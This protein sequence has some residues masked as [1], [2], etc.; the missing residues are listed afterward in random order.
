MHPPKAVTRVHSDERDDGHEDDE[1]EGWVGRKVDALFSPV[2]HFL[3]DNEK[4]T[5]GEEVSATPVMQQSSEDDDFSDEGSLQGVV[6]MEDDDFNPWQFIKSLPPYDMVKHLTPAVTLPPKAH[7]AP[8]I[9]LV[10]DLDETLVH[11]SVEE[12]SSCDLEFGVEFHGMDYQVYVKLR[13]HLQ[14]FLT[15]VSGQFEVIVFTASQPVYANELLDRIDPHRQLVHHRLFRDSCLQ[16]EGNF[17]KDLSVL[18]RDLKTT[19]LV[20]NSPHAFGYQLDNGVP[21]ES[22]FDDD[23]DRELVKL[24]RF[25]RQLHGQTDVRKTLRTKFQNNTRVKEAPAYGHGL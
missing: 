20:D 19:I 17:L 15:A 1:G 21:I 10:L 9:T 23:S 18:G 22:W 16:V 2:L 12:P 14:R 3:N 11:C 24:E 6:D 7:D 13:P 8:P 5:D 4:T 25:L